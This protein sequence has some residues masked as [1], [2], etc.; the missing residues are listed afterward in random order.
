MG[1]VDPAGA[2][3]ID[4]DPISILRGGPERARP[5][6]P[7][8][9]ALRGQALWQFH[10]TDTPEGAN[11]PLGPD[12]KPMGPRHNELRRMPV[13][14]AMYDDKYFAH[15]MDQ[16]DPFKIVSKVQNPG[17]RTGVQVM[18]G[19]FAIDILDECHRAQG[20]PSTTPT[21]TRVSRPKPS[22]RWSALLRLAGHTPSTTRARLRHRPTPRALPWTPET[23]HDVRNSWRPPRR[24]QA[25]RDL[26]RRLV[27]TPVQGDRALGASRGSPG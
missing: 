8:V 14:R 23:F 17:W 3:Y 22:P 19:C 7:P 4:A 15:F 11:N 20:A 26:L 10:A 25:G 21:P 13:R 24:F 2:V 16:V 9:H 18:M 12:G 27:P 1:Y 5:P 6:V